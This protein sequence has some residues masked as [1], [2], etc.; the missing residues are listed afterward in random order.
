VVV[1]WEREFKRF[2]PSI[3]VY[4]ASGESKEE[5]EYVM[6][7]LTPNHTFE[8]VIT[9]FETL[10]RYLPKFKTVKWD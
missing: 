3:K 9:T 7:F 4:A 6:S 8:A 5:R 2:C 10:E 1:N